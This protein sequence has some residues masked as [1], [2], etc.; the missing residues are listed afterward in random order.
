MLHGNPINLLHSNIL[1]IVNHIIII[2]FVKFNISFW[3]LYDITHENNGSPQLKLA[4]HKTFS[5]SDDQSPH[6]HQRQS[7][8]RTASG[9]LVKRP[10]DSQ[11]VLNSVSCN[12]GN[13]NVKKCL[14]S[15]ERRCLIY[16]SEDTVLL[17]W[18]YEDDLKLIGVIYAQE[19]IVTNA[20]YWNLT[21]D[22]IDSVSG[23]KLRRIPFGDGIQ[24]AGE[25]LEILLR[26]DGDVVIVSLVVNSKVS[27]FVFR[28]F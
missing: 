19:T 9:R 1:Y 10:K 11:N 26:M 3:R 8:V 2:L 25:A 23:E 6:H 15:K 17:A 16:I 14:T 5:L 20:S 4:L 27:F 12:E 7:Q 28:F 22:L 21:L 24:V 13:N 18:D